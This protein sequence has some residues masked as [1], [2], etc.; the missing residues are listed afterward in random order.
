MVSL[1]KVIALF[2]VVAGSITTASFLVVSTVQNSNHKENKIDL[3][4]ETISPVYSSTT[5]VTTVDLIT[6]TISPVISS[7]TITTVTTTTTFTSTTEPETSCK[8]GF[9]KMGMLY[10]RCFFIYVEKNHK[11]DRVLKRSSPRQES[12]NDSF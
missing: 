9:K 1:I 7:T 10:N 2:L 6:E 8:R 3:I 11:L 12:N 4:K 5:T